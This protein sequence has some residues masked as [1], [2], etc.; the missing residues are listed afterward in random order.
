M[1]RT[2]LDIFGSGLEAR[3]LSLPLIAEGGGMPKG[4]PAVL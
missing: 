4:E 1:L 2:P 3:H